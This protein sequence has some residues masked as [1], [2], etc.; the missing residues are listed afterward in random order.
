VT[1][2]E[3][4]VEFL[5][6]LCDVSAAETLPRF[7][8]ALQVDNKEEGGFD[9][10]TIA[11]REAERAIRAA[12]SARFPDHG[13][14]GEED[15]ALNGGARWCWVID[16]V[17]GTRAFIS[18]LPS[19]GTLIGLTCDG[20]PVAGVM[21]QPFTGERFFATDGGSWWR[22][23][24]ETQTLRTRQ[25][26]SLANAILMTTSPHIFDADEAQRYRSVEQRCRLFRYGFDCYA[27][28][29]VAAGQID[30]VV[31][32]SLKT[33]DIA[34]L[35]PVIENAGGIVTGW[36]GESAVEGG[37]VLACANRRI[38]AEALELLRGL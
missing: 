7:R 17:D 32:S 38:H 1:L 6:H 34:A 9:P 24:G 18:G 20:V 4:T 3:G 23:G 25:E 27:Y 36:N 35:I 21:D 10:V 19:W 8:S 16:P 28:A 12:I 13:I 37:R 29:M 14:I 2:P 30:L 31:E 11:D 15:H 22:R 33:Y 5:H 26:T